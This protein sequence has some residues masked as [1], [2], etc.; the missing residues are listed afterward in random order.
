M[1]NCKA[2]KEIKLL[3]IGSSAVLE[4]LYTEKEKKSTG[5]NPIT[6]WMHFDFKT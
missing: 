6:D 2:V 3:R 4:I 1:V 5:I